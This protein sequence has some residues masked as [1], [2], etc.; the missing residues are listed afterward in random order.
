MRQQ[1]GRKTEVQVNDDPPG[2]PALGF[3]GNPAP[4]SPLAAAGLQ[5]AS[6][7]GIAGIAGLALD[8]VVP[9]LADAATVFA[10]ERFLRGSPPGQ[11]DPGDVAAR[12]LGTQFTQNGQQVPP[13]VFP[14]GETIVFAASSPYVR[15]MRTG[16][17]VIFTQPDGR[18]LERAHP[19][20]RS[21]LSGYAC[22]LAVPM[23]AGDTAA[24]FLALARAPGRPA[25]SGSDTATARY[26]A[27]H[28]GTGIA[29]TVA[30]T[31][32]RT[33]TDT[34]QRGL[35]DSEPP[36]PEQL[37]VAAQCLPADGQ[38]IGGDWYSI[39]PLPAG[40]TGLVVGDVMG[41]GPE[42]AAAMAQLRTA[43]R[44]L[45]QLDLPPAELLRH[46]DRVTGTLRD[47]TLATCVYAVIDPVGQSCTL[48]AAGHLPAVL[49][50][51]DGTTRAPDLPVGPSL[52]LGLGAYGETRVKFPPGTIIALYTDGLVETRTRSY[53]DGIL[54]LRTE[55]ART[56]GPLTAVCGTLI[57]ALAPR[58]DDD[59]TLILARR[60]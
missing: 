50:L 49:A 21:V 26:L 46:L 31:R 41:H 35:Q 36:Q 4:A 33:I 6:G 27:A 23:I 52:G 30:L 57:R 47:A 15:C 54:T 7:T 28:A 39:I 48:A 53:E 13:A 17:P 34:L 24:G 56:R 37:E 14:P 29:N 51:P 22:F 8:A 18:T 25:F 2:T 38:L 60:E 16:G 19:G 9:S 43:A 11:D 1:P 10:A 45:S 12:R 59:I 55:L 42:A 40:R 5:L 3:P 58:P 20:A 44:A 32:L